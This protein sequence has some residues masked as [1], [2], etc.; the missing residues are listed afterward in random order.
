MF[1]IRHLEAME[2]LINHGSDEDLML[3]RESQLES[4]RLIA[5]VVS[6]LLCASY[7]RLHVQD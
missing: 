5:L 6:I 1:D 4:F 3:M 2:K 7:S